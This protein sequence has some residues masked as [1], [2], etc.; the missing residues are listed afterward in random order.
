LSE[1]YYGTLYSR[2]EELYQWSDDAVAELRGGFTPLDVVE[3]PDAPIALRMDN[4]APE[5]A[6]T[7][8]AVCAP[9]G[10]QRLIVV[11]CIRASPGGVWTIVGACDAS[12]NERAMW[13]KY[14]S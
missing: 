5:A 12:V 7:F 4:P 9:T 2:V 10:H 1:A 14:T 3:A 6:P 8:L 11:V 13:R